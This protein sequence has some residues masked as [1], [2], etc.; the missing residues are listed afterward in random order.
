MRLLIYGSLSVTLDKWRGQLTGQLAYQLDIGRSLTSLRIISLSDTL[1]C[2][3]QTRNNTNYINRRV[4]PLHILLHQ[5]DTAPI[6]FTPIEAT[7][8]PQHPSSTLRKTGASTMQCIHCDRTLED[9]I[10]SLMC[11]G[12][13][14]CVGKGWR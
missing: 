8:R 9:D 5:T 14:V 2:C 12:I 10:L 7:S 13:S 3:S 1:I 4:T 6:Y 11:F